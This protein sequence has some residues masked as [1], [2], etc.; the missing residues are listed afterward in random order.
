MQLGDMPVDLI[1]DRYDDVRGRL[2]GI[3][4]ATYRHASR[5]RTFDT[6][7]LQACLSYGLRLQDGG[8]VIVDS[9]IYETQGR[10]SYGLRLQDGGV[11][12][13]RQIGRA[14]CRERV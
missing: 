10:V 9:G 7:T 6:I 14:S 4:L 13:V 1:A 12:I 11:V 5:Q 8:V 2:Q 3:A